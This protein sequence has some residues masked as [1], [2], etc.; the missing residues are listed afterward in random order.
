MIMLE[1]N[2]SMLLAMTTDIKNK[3]DTLQV[4]KASITAASE[5]E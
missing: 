2:I 4:S 1:T 5:R 3:F